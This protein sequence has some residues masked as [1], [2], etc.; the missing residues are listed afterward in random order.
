MIER[1]GEGQCHKDRLIY[2]IQWSIDLEDLL[3]EIELLNK[4]AI[5]IFYDRVFLLQLQPFDRWKSTFVCHSNEL[6][7]I[8][9]N[10]IESNFLT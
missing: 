2:W 4:G 9:I 6:I 10:S 7:H 8:H 1:A 5:F 3:I